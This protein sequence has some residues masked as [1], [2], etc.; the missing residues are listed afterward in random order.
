M[1]GVGCPASGPTKAYTAVQRANTQGYDVALS[2]GL[3]IEAEQF[4]KVFRSNDARVGVAA[5]IAKGK[6]EF[7]GT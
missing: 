2:E 6:P 7:T 1:R 5:F 4:S 3:A